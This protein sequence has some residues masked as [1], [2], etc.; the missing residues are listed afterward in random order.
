MTIEGRSLGVVE[1]G[2]VGDGDIKDCAKN[3]SSFSGTDGE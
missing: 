3:K 1:N 2:L